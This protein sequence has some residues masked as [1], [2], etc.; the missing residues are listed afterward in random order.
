MPKRASGALQSAQEEAELAP[1]APPKEYS[2]AL[3]VPKC[4]RTHTLD[5][6][7]ARREVRPEAP[8]CIPEGA[9]RRPGSAKGAQESSKRRLKGRQEPS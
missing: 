6:F 3:A 1:K 5:G 4:A 7:P 8:E 2:G 9:Q